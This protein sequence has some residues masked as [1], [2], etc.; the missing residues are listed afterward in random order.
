MVK[1]FAGLFCFDILSQ[2]IDFIPFFESRSPIS[3][4]IIVEGRLMIE[5]LNILLEFLMKKSNLFHFDWGFLD[6]LC[7][8]SRFVSRDRVIIVIG[9]ERQN[10]G[11]LCFDTVIGKLS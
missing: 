1:F 6:S 3:L 2:Q 9:I 8:P 11:C 10:S 5:E 7:N 4:L